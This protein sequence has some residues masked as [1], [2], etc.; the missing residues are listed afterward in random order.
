VHRIELSRGAETDLSVLQ[1]RLEAL[2]NGS[3]SEEEWT[4]LRK[5]AQDAGKAMVTETD[6]WHRLIRLQTVDLP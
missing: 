5:I 6:N 3:G 2:A 4:D 1:T